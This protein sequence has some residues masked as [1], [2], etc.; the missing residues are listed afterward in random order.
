MNKIKQQLIIT[1]LFIVVIVL[2][3]NPFGFFMP[4]EL[5]YIMLGG[6]LVLFGV[7]MSFVLS[8]NPKDE[9]E[10]LH[11]YIANRSAYVWGS[12]ALVVGIIYQGISEGQIDGWLL[13]VLGVMVVSKVASLY[14]SDKY[15]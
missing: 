9:R 5:M 8:E 6:V 12:V 7:Y 14:Y 10:Q 13:I 2:L 3:L 1:A 15:K 11:R 4:T